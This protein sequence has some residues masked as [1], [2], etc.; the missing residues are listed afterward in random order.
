MVLSDR[1]IVCFKQNLI[2]Y[3]VEE[4]EK[5]GAVSCMNDLYNKYRTNKS[6]YSLRLGICC[7]WESKYSFLPSQKPNNE[8]HIESL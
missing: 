7:I 8:R 6:L 4:W 3:V 2:L 5:E 1:E